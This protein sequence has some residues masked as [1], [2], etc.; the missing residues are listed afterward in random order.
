[1]QS[2]WCSSEIWVFTLFYNVCR[3]RLVFPS[4]LCG[5]LVS[6]V[7]TSTFSRMLNYTT[8][9]CSNFSAYLLF[10]SK[11]ICT[12]NP[13]HLRVMTLSRQRIRSERD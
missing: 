5:L 1:M 6:Q 9:R 7:V 11:M 10:F 3:L 2:E 8:K 13:F 12:P 4:V